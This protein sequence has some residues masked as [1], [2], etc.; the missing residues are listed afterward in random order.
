[1]PLPH[2]T[3][4]LLFYTPLVHSTYT[5]L[6]NCTS[7][8]LNS[9]FVHPLV[10]L[11]SS[12]HFYIPLLHFPSKLHFYIFLL[13][14][15]STLHFYRS[16]LYSASTIFFYSPLLHNTFRLLFFKI[17]FL[18]TTDLNIRWNII[19][20]IILVRKLR[21]SIKIHTRNSGVQKHL[22]FSCISDPELYNSIITRLILSPTKIY[23]GKNLCWQCTAWP[24]LDENISSPESQHELE[25]KFE[26][27]ETNHVLARLS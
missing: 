12:L 27:L 1:M 11:P 20:T 18:K 21:N 2:Y 5:P 10:H 9:T 14:Y 22:P 16:L 6:L 26:L 24:E 7:T 17:H 25:K 8:L 13:H 23:A 15:I 3:S 4:T 19:E